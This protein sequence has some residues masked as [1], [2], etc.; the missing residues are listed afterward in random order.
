FASIA[1][2]N[3]LLFLFILSLLTSLNVSA[4]LVEGLFEVDMPV[5]DESK[6][7]RSAALD[8]GLIEVLIR[9]SGDS[10]IL[11]KITAPA[12]S[13]YV[14]RF[15]YITQ[16][17]PASGGDVSQ[18][19][20]VRYN[21]TKI[22]DF[23]R[24]QGIPIWGDRRS[25]VVMWMAVRDGSQRYILKDD[26]ISLIKSKL[27]TAFTRRGI[28][29]IWPKNDARDQKTVYF[30][31]IWAGFTDSVK[32]ASQR[33][34]SGPVIVGTLAWNGS[35]WKGDWTLLMD[36]EVSKWSLSGRDYTTLIARATDLSAD[37]MAE[38]FAFMESLDA[39]QQNTLAIEV[40]K[41][42]SV[43]DFRRIEKYL[44]SLSAVQSVQLSQLESERVFFD[45]SLRSK[46]DDLLS[47]IEAGS[48]ISRLTEEAGNESAE[49]LNDASAVEESVETTALNTEVSNPPVLKVTPYRFVLR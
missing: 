43:E 2:F 18:R 9:V 31:D 36:N 4:E 41:V 37:V 17:A 39:S 40:D 49:I 25:P 42:S 29:A 44:A 21:A 16:A 14:K 45:L 6:A 1:R 15:E 24:K 32:Q 20:W 26:D 38:K 33:Y 3:A 12:A 47:L 27:D 10:H 48:V 13:G 7:I 46:V 19:L 8:D 5:I 28:P 23:L 22:L 34:A 30:A 35:I 11:E